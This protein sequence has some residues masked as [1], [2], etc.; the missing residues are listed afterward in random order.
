MFSSDVLYL[1]PGEKPTEETTKRQVT[2]NAA[3]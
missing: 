3:A 1:E 2:V